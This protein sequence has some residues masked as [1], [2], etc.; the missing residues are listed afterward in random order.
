[1]SR[2]VNMHKARVGNGK[3]GKDHAMVAPG[4]TADFNTENPSVA[5]MMKGPKPLLVPEGSVL[6]SQAL[7]LA[8]A[9]TMAELVKAREELAQARAALAEGER[10]ALAHAAERTKIEAAFSELV[11]TNEGLN[12]KV[13]ELTA[14][15]DAAT[16][17]AAQR[18]KREG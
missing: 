9:P 18:A 11:A 17:P 3:T 13:A 6:A 8:D 15:L 5:L 16:K 7:S 1:M 2:L 4:A 14:A 10:L 12:A